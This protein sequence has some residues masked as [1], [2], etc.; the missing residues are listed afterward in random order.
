MG[1]SNQ[2][3]KNLSSMVLLAG[4]MDANASAVWYETFFANNFIV[5]AGT[6]WTALPT[7]R[8]LTA[9]SREVARANAEANPTLIQD[10]SQFAQAVRLTVVAGTN[11]STWAAYSVYGNTNSTL[12]RNWLLP[13]LVPQS[14]GAP[15]N[16]Y[17]IQLY[18]GNPASGG[19]LVS[20]SAGTTGT[21]ESKSVGWVFNYPSGLLLLATD[22]RAQISDPWIVGFRYIGPTAGS[23]PEPVSP[24]TDFRFTA[25]AGENVG[26]GEVLRMDDPAVN[27][28]G[29]VRARALNAESLAVGFAASSVSTGSPVGV[30]FNGTCSVLFESPLAVSDIGKTVWVSPAMSG[31]CTVTP[32]SASG[33]TAMKVG[34]LVSATGGASAGTVILALNLAARLL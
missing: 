23:E 15:S 8:T 31:R 6:V 33:Q 17:A 10:L 27:P 19:V 7:L 25:T 5:D 22:F 4:V 20:T 29:V 32:P 30:V 26:T 28:G 13:Q 11:G 12:L 9:G 21:G 34:T 3:Q 16:G 24:T 14:S 2:E 18:N 1:F